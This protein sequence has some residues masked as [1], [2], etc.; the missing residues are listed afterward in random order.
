MMRRRVAPSHQ[1]F[2]AES[3]LPRRMH[4]PPVER[5]TWTIRYEDTSEPSGVKSH[6]ISPAEPAHAGGL[7]DAWYPTRDIERA[8]PTPLDVNGSGISQ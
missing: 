7:A 3:T 4:I 2:L 6:R 8:T 1:L 5:A